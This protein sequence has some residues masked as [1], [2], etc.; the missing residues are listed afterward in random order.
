MLCLW[1]INVKTCIRMG[2]AIF[3][4]FIWGDISAVIWSWTPKF[5]FSPVATAAYKNTA[6]AVIQE[7]KI[8]SYTE[9]INCPL[10]QIFAMICF[11]ENLSRTTSQKINCTQIH[12]VKIRKKSEPLKDCCIKYNYC[13][14]GMWWFYHRAMHPKDETK[15]QT[16]QSLIR[17]LHLYFG[18]LV[19]WRS[20]LFSQICLSKM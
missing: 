4:M 11:C 5:V 8:Q 17:L 12:T 1:Q 16:V 3:K 9:K 14:I 18:S 10:Y 19:F 20:T 2:I 15:W 13:E 6:F 7:N